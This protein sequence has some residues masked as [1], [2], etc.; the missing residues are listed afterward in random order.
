M[1]QKRRFWH[2]A[3][4]RSVEYNNLVTIAGRLGTEFNNDWMG[5]VKGGYASADV[6]FFAINPT[7]GVNGKPGASREH[8]YTLGAGIERMINSK[9]II[10]LEYNYL[11]FGSVSQTA[12]NSDGSGTSV[13]SGGDH[14]IHLVLA[15]VSFKFGSE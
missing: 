4:E 1:I 15:R 9:A 13:W 7:N 6:E 5:Y 8:G 10:G 12:S 11:D 3:R 2:R 14:K